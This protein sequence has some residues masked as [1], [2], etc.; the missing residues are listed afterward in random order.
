[1]Q[2]AASLQALI[3]LAAVTAVV[4]TFWRRRDAVLSNSLFV[5]ATFLVTPYA[6][7]YDM[8]VF[9][10]VIIKLMDR[11]DNEPADWVVML[12]VWA[13]PVLTVPLGIMALPVSCVPL[14]ALAMRLVWRMRAL[15]NAQEIRVRP[16]LA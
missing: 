11:S 1:L 10:W 9:G 13:V 6:F 14:L 15:E 12:A 2:L 5:T 3:S 4:W 8:V 16:A 7:N